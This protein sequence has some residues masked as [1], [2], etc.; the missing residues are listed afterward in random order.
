GETDGERAAR[1]FQAT[2]AGNFEGRNVLALAAVPQAHD[3]A[4]LD[5]IRPK[6]YAA[7]AKRPPPLTDTKI[8]SSWNG[9]M[10]S[11]FARTGLA[12]AA[13]ATWTGP[14]ARPMR[15]SARTSREGSCGARDAIPGCWRTTRFL[16]RAW[17]ISTKPPGR[18]A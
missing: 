13:A 1:L 9:L 2:E 5:A 15:S 11:A 4:F 7:R 10:I 3:L 18:S 6:L 16:P 8:L 17:S 12:L 14:R